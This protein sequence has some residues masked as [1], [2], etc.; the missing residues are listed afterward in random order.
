MALK[1]IYDSL[2]F[3]KKRLFPSVLKNR[4]SKNFGNHITK[5]FSVRGNNNETDY[6]EAGRIVTAHMLL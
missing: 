4:C 1:I 3:N 2:N 6:I 5:N